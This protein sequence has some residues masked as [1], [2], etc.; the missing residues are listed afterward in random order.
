MPR[1]G[2]GS[3]K[4]EQRVQRPAPQAADGERDQADEQQRRELEA[5]ASGEEAVAPVHGADR[6][7]HGARAQRRPHRAFIPWKPCRPGPPNHP[8][9][10]WAP[11]A[12]SVSPTATRKMSSAALIMCQ[13]LDS[14]CE[15]SGW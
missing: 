14:K 8:N 5:A 15:L 13:P 7:E 12:A 9:T 4:A 11:C 1:T 3:R 2:S 10:F 6:D